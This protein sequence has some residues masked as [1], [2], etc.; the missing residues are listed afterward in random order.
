[1]IKRKKVDFIEKQLSKNITFYKKLNS[2]QKDELWS[3]LSDYERYRVLLKNQKR[4]GFG[5]DRFTINEYGSTNKDL[6]TYKNLKQWDKEQYTYQKKHGQTHLDKTY[7]LY[8]FGDWCRL[9]EKK[10]LI[11]A[12][13]FSVNSYIS[14]NISEQLRKF[15]QGLYPHTT[16]IKFIKNKKKSKNP[17]TGKKEYF[18]TMK[19]KTKAYGR[20]KELK[21]FRK[22]MMVFEYEILH[23]KIKKY[24]LKNMKNRT[25]RIVNKKETFDNF[26]LFLFSDNEALENCSFDTFLRDFNKLRR[27]HK[28]LKAIEKHFF[29]YAKQYLM[30]NFNYQ[31]S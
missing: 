30:E 21:A 29:Q 5:E 13:I 6:A 7:K 12:E 16:K 20:E 10:K 23:P 4:V 9:I 25:Y 19:S 8:L 2:E 15:E 27:D 18:S 11:Y 14:D 1:M 3:L 17:L 24:V 31:T 26:H 28:E 22:F